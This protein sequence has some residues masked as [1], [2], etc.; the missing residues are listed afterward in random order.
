MFAR[1]HS[2]LFPV[3]LTISLL[4]LLLEGMEFTSRPPLVAIEP[5]YDPEM[6]I[7]GQDAGDFQI[8]GNQYT[9]SS[10]INSES[11]YR[12]RDFD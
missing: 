10:L 11:F 2:M 12:D 3:L 6:F 4:G 7:V 1:G 9:S 8:Y 5:T